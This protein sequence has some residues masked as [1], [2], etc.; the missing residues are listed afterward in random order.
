LEAAAGAGLEGLEAGFLIAGTGFLAAGTGFLAAGAGF[1]ATFLGDTLEAGL[2]AG[3]FA[4]GF[5][6]TTFLAGRGFLTAA[7][8]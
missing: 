7:L 1:G 8:A 2:G 4:T 5:L 3:F 6:A